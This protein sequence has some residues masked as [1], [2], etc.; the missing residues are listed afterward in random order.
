MS[1]EAGPSSVSSNK[2]QGAAG[3]SASPRP[4]NSSASGDEKDEN[5]SY[6]PMFKCADLQKILRN[7]FVCIIGDSVQRGIYKDLVLALQSN[8]LLDDQELKEKVFCF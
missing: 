4:S 2:N 3:G 1:D 7:R 5:E 6:Q 8:R